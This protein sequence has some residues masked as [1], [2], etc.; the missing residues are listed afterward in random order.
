MFAPL[1]FPFAFAITF[2]RCGLSLKSQSS[3][4]PRK[5][6]GTQEVEAPGCGWLSM[7]RR[8]QMMR[9][10]D[11]PFP[12]IGGRRPNQGFNRFHGFIRLKLASSGLNRQTPRP[13]PP[14]SLDVTTI[15]EREV[16]QRDLLPINHTGCKSV[17][18]QREKVSEFLGLY[19]PR[20]ARK[21]RKG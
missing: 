20:K 2:G 15:R 18:V 1:E 7:F 17:N 12:R 8:I 14:G 4:R 3:Q 16:Y 13:L 5:S 21:G 11:T 19:M 6:W 10:V 9:L